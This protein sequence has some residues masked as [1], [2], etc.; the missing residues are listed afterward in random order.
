[1]EAGLV[2][3]VFWGACVEAGLVEGTCWGVFWGACWDV[4]VEGWFVG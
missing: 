4:C 3:A 1:M 2:E